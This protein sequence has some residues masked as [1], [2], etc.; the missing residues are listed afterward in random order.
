MRTHM[1]RTGH[2]GTTKNDARIRRGR[3]NHHLNA[4]AEVDTNA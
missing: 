1:R 4:M 2:I 3:A